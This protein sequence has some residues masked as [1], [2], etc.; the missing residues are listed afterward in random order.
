MPDTDS[1]LADPVPTK[2]MTSARFRGGLIA[3]ILVEASWLV[4]CGG[5]AYLG[6]SGVPALLLL[7]FALITAVATVAGWILVTS[8][9]A[10]G[11]AALAIF[12]A[13]VA[14]LV[15]AGV[16]AFHLVAGSHSDGHGA[17]LGWALVT[18]LLSLI[19]LG[20]VVGILG[21][22]SDR[23]DKVERHERALARL[24]GGRW[25]GARA[26][27]PELLM[28]PLAIPGVC[29]YELKG[30]FRYAVAGGTRVVLVCL[31]PPDDPE[32][33]AA[34][35]SSWQDRLRAADPDARVRSLLVVS[36]EE[37]PPPPAG[38]LFALGVTP[39]TAETLLDTV[40]PWLGEP[41]HIS[42]PIAATLGQ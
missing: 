17:K 41:N 8:E 18:A 26:E 6:R 5:L 1:T 27:P 21:E 36:A 4:L 37:A 24:A 33:L 29:G 7:V 19:A 10:M 34:A 39:V 22:V 38:Q 28:P 3:L 9:T 23:Q 40:G 14:S 16:Q 13:V 2:M 42:V 20:A 35:A 31:A 15:S 12:A 11:L 25:L 30:S 32:E